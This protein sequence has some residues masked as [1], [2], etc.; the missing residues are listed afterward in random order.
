MRFGHLIECSRR[1]TL[2]EKSDTNW[3]GEIIPKPFL[4]KSK[5]AI[6]SEQ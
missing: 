1:K 5:F 2:I 6:S 3:G 4:K